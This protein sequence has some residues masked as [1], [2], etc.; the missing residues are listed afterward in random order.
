[1]TVI[2]IRLEDADGCVIATALEEGELTLQQVAKPDKI[3]AYKTCRT[4]VMG[5]M[6]GGGAV[7]FRT[8]DRTRK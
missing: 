7:E 6:M 8:D 1:M 4:L 3:Q 2:H 5:Q